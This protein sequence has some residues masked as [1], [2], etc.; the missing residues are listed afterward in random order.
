MFYLGLMWMYQWVFKLTRPWKSGD[1][2][3]NWYYENEMK[4]LMKSKKNRPSR[5]PL[6]GQLLCLLPRIMVLTAL[7]QYPYFLSQLGQVN[8]PPPYVRWMDVYG[9][10]RGL[11]DVLDPLPLAKLHTS[12]DPASDGE[13]ESFADDVNVNQ[14][15]YPESAGFCKD[16]DALTGCCW[17]MI[18]DDTMKNVLKMKLG[19]TVAPVKI[20]AL[21]EP[22]VNKR[23]LGLQHAVIKE[24]SP[25]S[26]NEEDNGDNG[27]F[28][29]IMKKTLNNNRNNNTNK[30]VSLDH[31]KSLPTN[32]RNLSEMSLTA[33]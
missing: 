2:K 30:S 19:D 20:R 27:G 3:S 9:G 28:Y 4:K 5:A 1:V 12:P 8:K 23:L 33:G 22:D 26:P 32:E 16:F 24:A 6:Y 31:N 25:Y 18:E 11:Q 21:Q 14:V 29:V 15:Q 7:L 13:G 10:M 17:T